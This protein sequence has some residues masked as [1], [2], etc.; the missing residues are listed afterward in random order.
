VKWY[1][2]SLGKRKIIE[3]IVLIVFMIFFVGPLL[4]LVLLAFS[5]K[6]QYPALYPEIWSFKW[7]EFVFSNSNLSRSMILSFEFAPI[8]TFLSIIICVPAAYAFARIKFP[9]R[10]WFLFS[11]LLTNAFPKMGLYVSIAVLFYKF[12]LMDTFVGVILIQLVNTLMFMT[13]IPASAFRSVHK[14]QE[15]AAHDAGAN[16]LK[17]FFSVTLPMALPGILVASI[18]AFLASLDEAQ[19]TLMVGTPDFI[20]MPVIM[21]SLVTDYPGTAGAVF[22]IL[23]TLPSIILLLVARRFLGSNAMANGFQMK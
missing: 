11:F 7:W 14:A 19:G 15:E 17:V 20:T 8:V 1:L 12:G 9:F 5:G 23:L 18:F 21:Y 6:W 3:L 16:G 10:Q 2:Q 13:W 22:S 4:N